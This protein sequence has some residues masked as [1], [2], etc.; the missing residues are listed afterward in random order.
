MSELP[1]LVVVFMPAL[2]V[3]LIQKE[4]E[5]GESLT[6][7][8]VLEIRN[9]AVCMR[10]HP[11]L[12]AKMDEIR[13]Y[14]D[15]DPE[16]CWYEWQ[17]LRRELGRKP[18]LDPGVKMYME[19]DGDPGYQ[20]TITTAQKTLPQ[21]RRMF[22]EGVGDRAMLKAELTD[23]ESKVLVWLAITRVVRNDFVTQVFEIP[24][25]LPSYQI[26][27]TVKVAS[28]DVLDWMII[29]NGTLYGGYSIR[30]RRRQL[31]AAEIAAFDK[32]LGVRKYA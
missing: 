24:C 21:F 17:M 18:D 4:D 6:R 14:F 20:A 23:I 10:L 27:D 30:H 28:K 19:R 3:L 29:D 5:K 22:V 13:G 7:E 9:N 1:Y 11:E 26:G 12:A 8:E 16:N 15:I 25:V 31:K 32:H 2:R